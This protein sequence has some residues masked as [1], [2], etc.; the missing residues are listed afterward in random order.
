MVRYSVVRKSTSVALGLARHWSPAVLTT[1]IILGVATDSKDSLNALFDWVM[2]TKAPSK[3]AVPSVSGGP[4]S[5]RSA[6]L[7]LRPEPTPPF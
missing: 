4:A 7:E 5:L 1:V 2:P 3:T 6:T